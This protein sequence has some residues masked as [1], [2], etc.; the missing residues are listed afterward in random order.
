MKVTHKTT[1]LLTMKYCTFILI[2]AVTLARD[3]LRAQVAKLVNYKG[4]VVAP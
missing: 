2:L 1:Q 4:R 3:T